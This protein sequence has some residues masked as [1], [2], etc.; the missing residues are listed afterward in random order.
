[1]ALKEI[2]NEFTPAVVEHVASSALFS[3][4]VSR[5]TLAGSG[6]TWI[7]KEMLD[8]EVAKIELL[9]QEFFR[10]I[11]P[12]QGET[13]LLENKS[14]GVH[15]ILSEEVKGYRDL[16]Q[17]EA[18][19]FANGHYTGLGQALV[20]AMFLQEIDLKNGN[21]GLDEQNRVAKIDGDWC[22]AEGRYGGGS[23][24]I[25]PEAIARLPYPQDFYT[26]NW[27]DLIMQNTMR[28]KSQIVN[29]SLSSSP[30]FRAE[31]N[32]ALLMI[33]L[34]PDSFIGHFVDAYMP[35]GGERFVHLIKSRR[36]QLLT[37]ALQNS[38]FLEYCNSAAALQDYNNLMVHMDSFQANGEGNVLPLHA[39]EANHTS[40][41]GRLDI[42]NS[43]LAIREHGQIINKILS[44]QVNDQDILL[45]T[46][47]ADM[48]KE[49]VKHSSNP[50]KLQ[51]IKKQLLDVLASVSSAEVLAVKK[52]VSDLRDNSHWYTRGI[53]KKTERI[54]AAL[55]TIPLLERGTVISDNG[56][57]NKVQEA[58]ASHRH[59]GKGGAVYKAGEQIDMEYSAKTF[60][61]LKAQFTKSRAPT[62]DEDSP[63]QNPQVK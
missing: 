62:N 3:H 36:D 13:R 22:F 58:L 19:N 28:A 5:G 45:Q 2:R 11:I 40:V 43:F 15:Y 51:E 35:A 18:H 4:D 8:P 30:Q 10:L 53:I 7:K 41:A 60:K 54:E 12:H 9:A 44:H 17:G 31:V 33:C 52:A 26:F 50:Q 14:T 34:L 59:W 1:M 16:P 27:L 63:S 32:Q 37:S 55:C 57:A 29:P 38:S 21:I 42:I 49:L 24:K 6:K 48:R 23:Y 25:T 56:P 47:V 46:Y 20:T 61:D 39:Q